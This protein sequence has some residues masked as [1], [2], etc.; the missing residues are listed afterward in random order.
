MYSYL[1]GEFEKTY[2][3]FGFLMCSIPFENFYLYMY[4]ELMNFCEGLPFRPKLV[5]QSH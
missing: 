3:L 2:I 4:R 5:T 1:G